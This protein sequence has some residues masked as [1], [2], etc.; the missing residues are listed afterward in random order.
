MTSKSNT[1]IVIPIRRKSKRA[2][3]KRPTPIPCDPTKTHWGAVPL[4]AAIAKRPGTK[5]NG[6]MIWDCSGGLLRYFIVL[7]A[8]A[9]FVPATKQHICFKPQGE[10]ARIL[11]ISRREASNYERTLRD[12]GL[13]VVTHRRK[14]QGRFSVRIA[15]VRMNAPLQSVETDGGSEK[16]A[17][18]H[19]EVANDTTFASPA[20]VARLK[21]MEGNNPAR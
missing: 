8:H 19:G 12:L 5:G 21:P 11:G 9:Q 4:L 14:R 6:R 10:I 17:A 7:G 3:R 18:S 15:E 13:I 1:A 20:N 2:G 16:S